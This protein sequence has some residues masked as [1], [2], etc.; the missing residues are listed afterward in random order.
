[1]PEEV[2]IVEQC[3]AGDDSWRNNPDVQPKPRPIS[4]RIAKIV[5]DGAAQIK[6]AEEAG[7]IDVPDGLFLQIAGL[8]AQLNELATL[9]SPTRY[10][11]E[12]LPLIDGM[13]VLPDGLEVFRQ[14]ILTELNNELN[15]PE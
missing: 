5:E 12:A 9:V 1:M 13:G 4:A 2:V 10:V 7:L 15:P 14:Q 11:T 8:L 6:A 3:A